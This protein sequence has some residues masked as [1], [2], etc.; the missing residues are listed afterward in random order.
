MF[1]EPVLPDALLKDPVFASDIVVSGDFTTQVG[2]P[3]VK[4]RLVLITGN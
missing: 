2:M 3:A 4:D 1:S